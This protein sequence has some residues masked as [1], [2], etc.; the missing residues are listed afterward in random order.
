MTAIET[1][2]HRGFTV[3]IHHDPD[4]DSPR[5]WCNTTTMVLSHKRYNLPNEADVNFDDF[6]SFTE[7]EAHLRA[8]HDV[9]ALMPVWGYD[10]GQLALH[11]G[12]RVGQFADPW[13]SGCLGIVF[14]TRE[15][16]EMCGTPDDMLDSVMQEEVQT[17]SEWA[18]GENY[19][20]IVT[21]PDDENYDGEE[22]DSCWGYVASLDHCRSEAIAVA[23]RYADE[24][25]KNASDDNAAAELPVLLNA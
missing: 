25:E 8:E 20:Y 24:V 21:A 6:D 5:D 23:D 10:H 18:N 19:G 2:E 11:A 15:G 1:F 9:V 16:Q 3:E 4:A 22:I 17:Y 14:V 7:V 13:D 12:G